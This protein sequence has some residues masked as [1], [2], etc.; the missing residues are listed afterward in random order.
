M[1]AG[2]VNANVV[3]V[4]LNNGIRGHSIQLTQKEN[5]KNITQHTQNILGIW[6]GNSKRI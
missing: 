4:H 1:H 6:D 3:V 5:S 2:C